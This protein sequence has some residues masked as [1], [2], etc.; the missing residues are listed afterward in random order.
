MLSDQTGVQLFSAIAAPFNPTFERD[1]LRQPL[2]LN[3]E[4]VEKLKMEK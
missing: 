2:N 3:V 4:A 1:W